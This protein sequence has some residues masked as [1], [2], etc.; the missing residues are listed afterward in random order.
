MKVTNGSNHEKS[1]PNV[2]LS[3]VYLRHQGSTE[4]LAPA[5]S[6]DAGY[7]AL[8][9]GADGIYLGL[10]L[11][12]ARAEAVNFS[13]EELREIT[14]YAHGLEP[15]RRVFVAVNTV[16]LQSELLRVAEILADLAEVGVDGIIVQD[17][18]LARIVRRY[19][20]S[21]RLHASTQMAIHSLAGAR[22]VA[23][24]GFSR[25]TLARELTLAEIREIVHECGIETEVFIHGA[26]CYSYSGLCLF[27]SLMRGGSGNRGRCHYPCREACRI[28]GKGRPLFPFSM[29][30][31]A[32][33]DRVKALKQAGVTS[34]K[35]EGRMKSPLYVATVV[36]YYR[37]LLD[38]RLDPMTGRKL[39]AEMRTVFAR[40]W[41]RLYFDSPH[42]RN[43][44]DLEVVGHRGLLI[45]R[46]EAVHRRGQNYALRFRTTRPIQLHDGL[47][48][49]LPT[50]GSPY[51]FPVSDLFIVSNQTDS[52]TRP[53]FQ[54]PS[55][56][57]VEVTLPDSHPPIPIGAPIYWS[58]SQEVK[59][60]YRFTRP[61]PGEYQFSHP[62]HVTLDVTPEAL[63]TRAAAIVPFAPPGETT[64][65]V[66]LRGQFVTA[67]SPD[68]LLPTARKAF[69]RL[70][71]TGL[72]LASFQYT[73]PQKLFVPVTTLNRLRR[74]VVHEVQLLIQ[75]ARRHYIETVQS[76]VL[77]DPNSWSPDTPVTSWEA[78][79]TKAFSPV[80]WQLKID[81]T[82]YVSEFQESDWQEVDEL[83][84]DIS[85][86]PE[87]Q[88]QAGLN[89]L[90]RQFDHDR[91][92]LALPIVIRSAQEAELRFR[93]R[94]FL[95]KGWSKWEV[96]GLGGL[97]VLSEMTESSG[98]FPVPA[99]DISAD[100]P[101]YVLN[102]QAALA[103]SEL[104]LTRFTLSPEDG[105][106]NMR[107]L[108]AEFGSRAVVIVYQDTPLF[109][110]AT[111][112]R[113]TLAQKC[114]P[115]CN[116][117]P[118][119]I[120]L[121]FEGGGS[122]LAIATGCQ[123]IVVGMHPYCLVEH[124]KPLV[125]IGA[126]LLRVD[127]VWRPYTPSEARTIWRAVRAG[128]KLHCDCKSGNF[129]CGLR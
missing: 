55:H 23:A 60:K 99:L 94:K 124:L 57:L 8:Q 105:K 125:K 20:P 58:S 72:R 27:S 21:L 87:Q 49:D 19:F 15:P 80:R 62:L 32:L 25:V 121:E 113:R 51:G 71:G 127:F 54:V 22:A 44:V 13:L 86:D 109:F 56:S 123:T 10:H 73:N 83:V 52:T 47:Q 7:A 1:K 93:I 111:C 118:P 120:P 64:C 128:K 122:V 84:V 97:R 9:Y 42:A 104:G 33:L 37:Q 126:R 28:S 41:T 40:P 108:L 4:L 50:R 116:P 43:V 103:L 16:V 76:K 5:G 82:E 38:D 101:L 11:F 48:I 45:G 78:Q 46:V 114:E 79:E 35:I 6:P 96:S 112:L 75:T 2:Q 106:T 98:A 12:S 36:N 26:L 29:K 74:Q 63:T 91:I 65:V 68:G 70:G 18:G 90:A 69:E 66:T 59:R 39:E 102:R 129:A 92:R 24:L 67:T 81:R 14:A 31:L 77:S 88:V 95:E 100:W 89:R 85:R 30:D 61:R 17:L 3:R 34:L 110:S 115:P 119:A 53:L 117:E 107:E